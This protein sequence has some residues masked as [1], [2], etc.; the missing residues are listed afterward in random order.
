MDWIPITEAMP[1]PGKVVEAKF[2]EYD[3][4]EDV[5]YMHYKWYIRIPNIPCRYKP[6]HW[7]EKEVKQNGA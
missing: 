1:N 5:F 4:I 3:K 7:R 6:T 2:A